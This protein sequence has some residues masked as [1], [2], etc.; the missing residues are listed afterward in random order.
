MK[1]ILVIIC[2]VGLIWSI[3]YR[4]KI[5]KE[6]KIALE[7]PGH[8]YRLRADFGGVLDL[9]LQDSNHIIVFEREY[10][11]SVRLSNNKGQE[12]LMSR[13]GLGS[14]GPELLVSCIQDSLLVKTWRFNKRSS[15]LSIYKEISYYFI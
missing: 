13:D 7:T 4:K 12:L 3:N 15:D 9:L 2:I 11:Q 8:A 10:D 6:E 14:H 1:V 5:D